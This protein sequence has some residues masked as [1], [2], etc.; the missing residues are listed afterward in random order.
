M[1]K[2]SRTL[3]RSASAWAWIAIVA[4]ARPGSVA[5]ADGA[6][7]VPGSWVR[8]TTG[9]H[10]GVEG[11]LKTLDGQTLMLDRR[12]E[13]GPILI[14]REAITGLDVRRRESKKGLGFLIGVVAGGVI[15]H[16]LGAGTSG[17]G[18]QGGETGFAHLC[19]LDDVNKAGATILGVLGGAVLGVI[20]AP[21][22]KWTRNVPL[23]HAHVTLAPVR[24]RGMM[25]SVSVG[26]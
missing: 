9:A 1:K 22:A 6:A 3:I 2:D 25:L 14:P 19:A 7:I 23:D 17:P 20:V 16:A 11:T 10:A 12:G 24:G 18:C 15:G 4:L 26:F 8:V 5:A 13:S 21:G